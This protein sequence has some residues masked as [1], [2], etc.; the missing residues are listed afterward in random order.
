MASEQAEAGNDD[1]VAVSNATAEVVSAIRLGES[2]LAGINAMAAMMASLPD[3]TQYRSMISTSLPNMTR[4]LSM[5]TVPLPDIT[6]SLSLIAASLP[7]IT[8]YRST[9][10]TSLPD[11]TRALSM[12]TIPLPDMTPF[13]SMIA[14]SLPDMTPYRSI[15]AAGLPEMSRSLSLIAA[16]LPDMALYRSMIAAGLPEL[17]RSLSMLSVPLP[18]MSPSLS[19]IAASL[20]DMTQYRSA[21]TAGWAQDLLKSLPSI[22]ELRRAQYPAN[23]ADAD[24]EI[25]FELFE[26]IMIEEGLPLAWVPSASTIEALMAADSRATRRRIVGNRW[27]GIIGDCEERLTSL[28]S[29]EAVKFAQFALSAI[30]ALRG[31]H[32]SSAQALAATTLDSILQQVMS[33]SERRAITGQTRPSADDYS[34]R[35]YFAFTQIWAIHRPFFPD[36]GDSLPASFS[37]HGAVHGVSR[38]QYSRVNTVIALAH[39]TSLLC[40]VDSNYSRRVRAIA[41]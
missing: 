1:V 35:Q 12:L 20:P 19:L 15:A 23:I 27:R 28:T 32:A 6:P 34:A 14:S 36:R 7:D 17:S 21:L 5:L 37:R 38:R 16:S 30:R 29:I 22:S 24:V 10:S 40:Y 33:R 8:Q 31:G 13:T 41:A 11:M 39:L 18:D 2:N 4:A 25:D 26:E 9:I 3:M